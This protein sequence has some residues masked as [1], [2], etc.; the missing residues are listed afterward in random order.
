ME[1]IMDDVEKEFL[2]IY[3]LYKDD[4]IR[5]AFSYTKNINDA[6]DITQLVFIKLY[7]CLKKNNGNSYDKS[8]LFKVTRN[9]CKD[10]FKSS[11]KKKVLLEKDN[12]E[13]VSKSN[14]IDMD[15]ALMQAL[16]SLSIKYREVLYLYYYEGYKIEEIADILNKKSSTIKSLLYRGRKKLSVVLK[17]EWE[18]AK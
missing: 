7:N 10:L 13:I 12:A 5:L 8:W 15:N 2:K 18:Y 16:F 3:N 11:W 9:E 17:E 4:V 6:E 14:D 1:D